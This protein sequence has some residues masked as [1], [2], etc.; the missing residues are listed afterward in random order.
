MTTGSYPAGEGG[1]AKERVVQEFLP[2]IRYT[3]RRLSWR[4]SPGLSEEDLISAGVVGLLDALGRFREG[5]VKL[6]TYVEYRIKGAM[7]DELR[8]ADT[9]PRTVRDRVNALKS[10]HG[11]LEQTLGRL[12]E[13][14]EVA[15]ALG[16]T[17]EAYYKTLREGGAA[18]HLRFEDFGSR[19]P[20][21][22]GGGLLENLPDA[23]G[24]DPLSIV[25][26]ASLRDLLAKVIADLPEKERLVLSL[27]Y[28]DELTM[29]E[30]GKALGLTEGRVCQL[31]GQALLRCKAR[32]G[33]AFA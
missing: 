20:D 14:T 4:L 21:E 19:R 5:T 33:I 32:F 1:D 16:V 22:G 24:K 8:A 29:K 30:I 13:D 18:L 2:F 6:K 23:E 10:A 12:P 9:I 17:L 7:L 28:W 11:R 3:A 15:R 26:G 27:Y 31:H 25:E